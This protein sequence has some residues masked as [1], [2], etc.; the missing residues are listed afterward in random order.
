MGEMIN[1][2]ERREKL[3]E[4]I[5]R[6]D[7]LTVNEL[8]KNFKGISPA[9]I[10]R[11]L[12]ILESQG[13]IE[14]SYGYVQLATKNFPIPSLEKKMSI[15]VEEKKRIAKAVLNLIE[16]GDTLF[17]DTG[18]TLVY[19]A[20]ELKTLKGIMVITN[21]IPVIKELERS[22]YIKIV[23]IGGVYQ[24]NEQCFVGSIAEEY[25]KRYKVDKAIIGADGFSFE[26]GVTS[27]DPENAGVTRLVAENAET[28]IVA[29]DYTKIGTRGVIPIASI[30]EIDILV[31]NKELEP[32]K[33]STLKE[34]G[35]KVILT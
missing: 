35:I 8:I 19:I 17:L 32:E 2:I 24:F 9:S 30:E 20:R 5:K 13:I 6:K 12:R 15:N 26:E 31:T 10:R 33:V 11:D 29:A 4:I 22:P 16:E 34:R 25:V 28:V 23:G 1:S 3:V 27:H 18:S 7:K 21:S 14:R